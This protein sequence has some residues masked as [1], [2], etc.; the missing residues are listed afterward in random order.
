MHNLTYGT[1]HPCN[2][3]EFHILHIPEHSRLQGAICSVHT[4]VQHDRPPEPASHL[5]SSRDQEVEHSSPSTLP[6]LSFHPDLPDILNLIQQHQL[7]HPGWK[8]GVIFDSSSS[9]VPSM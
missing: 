9:S 7:D 6:N 3:E 8:P 4:R 1:Q 5:I 2:R